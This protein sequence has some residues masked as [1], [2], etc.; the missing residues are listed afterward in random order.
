MSKHKIKWVGML[1]IKRKKSW[2]TTIEKWKGFGV[3]VSKYRVDRA[4]V[5]IFA[6]ETCIYMLHS[7]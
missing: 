4:N 6:Y 2:Y 3:F 5:K 1:A 7:T